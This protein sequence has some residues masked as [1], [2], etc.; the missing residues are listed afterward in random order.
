[1]DTIRNGYTTDVLLIGAGSSR[2][3]RVMVGEKEGWEGQRVMSLDIEERHK[4]DVVWNLERFPWPFDD[5]GADE[6]HAYEVLEHLGHQG[7]V[8]TFFRHFYEC[9]RI[10]KPGGHLAA[11]VPMWNS[12]WAWGDP[13]HTRI[14]SL[15][16]L[17][18]LNQQEYK[19][20]VGATPMSDYRR[21]WRGDFDL[22]ANQE[23]EHTLVFVLQA[24]KPPRI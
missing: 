3:R 14:I 23:T 5:N 7:D 2:T 11:T 9:W 1:M 21:Y 6:I 20:Q 22:V 15:H 4:P 19:K 24:V 12:P 10:L 8:A 16:S 17:T 13:G 18:F